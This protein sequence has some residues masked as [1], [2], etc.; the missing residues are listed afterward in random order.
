MANICIK[1]SVIYSNFLQEIQEH[2]KVV[3]EKTHGRVVSVGTPYKIS[4]KYKEPIAKLAVSN[5]LLKTSLDNLNGEKYGELIGIYRSYRGRVETAII[6]KLNNMKYVVCIDKL[7][8]LS[9]FARKAEDVL[10]KYKS[11]KEKA[12]IFARVDLLL[13]GGI[14]DVIETSRHSSVNF[15]SQ[16]KEILR[17]M[18]KTNNNTPERISGAKKLME[19]FLLEKYNYKIDTYFREF[20]SFEEADTY[21]RECSDN[22]IITRI[23]YLEL[24][25][26]YSAPDIMVPIM[27]LDVNCI[28]NEKFLSEL[29]EYVRRYASYILN[30]EEV[31]E[32]IRRI[33]EK[34]G[35]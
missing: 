3:Q 11:A 2:A 1:M 25:S 26:G 19:K 24:A 20:H 7:K 35:S 18:L 15:N 9:E 4:E 32:S 33:Y 13:C 34:K 30:L 28:Y 12:T 22:E 31:K 17:V 10:N 16:E 29:S 21:I 23:S 6:I 8:C 14:V 27:V 5:S